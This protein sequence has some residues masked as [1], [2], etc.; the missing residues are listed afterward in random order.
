[1]IIQISS[2]GLNLRMAGIFRQR[3]GNDPQT[4]GADVFCSCDRHSRASFPV[5]SHQ[6]EQAL[7]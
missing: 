4:Q 5:A 1:M 3:F 2:I 6:F 7:R